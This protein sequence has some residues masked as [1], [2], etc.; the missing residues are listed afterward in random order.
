MNLRIFI[1]GRFIKVFSTISNL[2]RAL[3]GNKFERNLVNT[4]FN[5]KFHNQSKYSFWNTLEVFN[6]VYQN[7]I[8]GDIVEC[9]V[10]QGINLVFFQKLI[11]KYNLRNCKIYGFDTFEGTPIPGDKDITKYNE[12]M[13]DEYE[14]LKKNDGTSGWNNTSIDDVRKN[15]FNNTNDNENLILI[16]GKVEETLKNNNNI[17]EKISILRLDTSLYEGTKIEF[18]KLFPKVQKGGSVIVEGYGQYKGV[19]KATDEYLS[20]TK[21]F[22]N[23]NYI[24]GRAVIYL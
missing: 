13:R 3:K 14:K 5:Y 4:S 16:K 15:Y 18:E 10:W 12:I 11:D 20:S 2:V 6:K 8:D 24:L 19:K 21:Y 23:Y 17:P 22:I 7:N 1:Q 9:G